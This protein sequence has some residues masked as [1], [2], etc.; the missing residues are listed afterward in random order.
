M[1]KKNN[2]NAHRRPMT[3]VEREAYDTMMESLRNKVHTCNHNRDLLSEHDLS[4]VI[5][6]AIA[7][8]SLL[9]IDHKASYQRWVD[10]CKESDEW[11]WL[12]V[13]PQVYKLIYLQA[14]ELLKDR[15]AEIDNAQWYCVNYKDCDEGD[16]QVYFVNADS[17]E[18]AREDVR[19]I[20]LWGNK[21]V[22]MFRATWDNVKHEFQMGQRVSLAG[23][24][25]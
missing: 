11:W 4:E 8:V 20:W 2:I 18:E 9:R 1:A 23:C 5:Y 16:K 10:E 6:R 13:G 3:K 7:G 17:D 21:L 15:L 14:E 22:S 24:M 19:S 25:G 12:Y